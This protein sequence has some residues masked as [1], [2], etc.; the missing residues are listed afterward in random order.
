MLLRKGRVA[1]VR[2][3]R[4]MKKVSTNVVIIDPDVEFGC[5]FGAFSIFA[6]VLRHSPALTSTATEYKQR[7]RQSPCCMLLAAGC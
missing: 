7:T 1:G 6:S 5:T 4:G 3:E 2:R